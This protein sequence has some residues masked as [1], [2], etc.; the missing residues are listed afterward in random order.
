MRA[1]GGVELRNSENYRLCCPQCGYDLLEVD[2]VDRPQQVE[3]S[4]DVTMWR[5]REGG[6]VA[7]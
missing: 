6:V 7:G 3:V 5:R 1:R 2:V 4:L